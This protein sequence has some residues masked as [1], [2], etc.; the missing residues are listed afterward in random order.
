MDFKDTLHLPKTDFEMRGNLVSKQ[1]HY[2]QKWAD[3]NLYHLMREVNQDKTPFVFHDGPPYANGDIHVG[4]ALNKLLK[5]FVVRSR[6]KLGYRVHFVPGWDTHGLPIENEITKQGV[7]RKELPLS[8]F[9]ALCQQYAEKQ[10]Q[11]QMQE[12]KNLGTVADYDHPYITYHH[13]YEATQVELFAKMVERGMIYKGLKPVYWSPSSETALAEAEIEYKDKK[14]P[15]I[16]VRFK[17]KDG[18]GVLEEPNT[19][20]VIWTTTP[21]TIPGNLA[22]SLHPR[23]TYAQVKV[24]QDK[25]I[26]LEEFVEDL[27][28][29]FEFE[30]FE[31]TNRYLGSELEH[32]ITQHPLYDRDSIVILGEHVT[33]DSGTGCVHT[34]PG[35]GMD[36]YIVGLKYG[37][38]PYCNVDDRGRMMEM[39]GDWLAGQTTEEANKT[40]TNR[41]HEQGDLL[42][43]DFIT[44]SYPHDWRTKQPII[45]RATDQWFASIDVIRDELLEQVE[46]VEWM[47][48]WGKLRMTN[49][50]KDR[51]DWTISRQ[52]A[53]GLPI[54]IFYAQDKTPIM[55]QEVF[56]HVADLFR[57]HGS[58]IWFEKEAK[59]LLPEGYTH[60]NSP[61]GI[62]TKEKDIL[63]VWFDSGSSHTAALAKH[64]LKVPHD[65]YLEGSDQYRGWFNSSLII[66]TAVFNTAPYKQVLTHGFIVDE[67]GEK[68]SKSKGKALQP[69][70]VTERLGAEILRLWVASV[71]YTSDVSISDALLKQVAEQYRKIRNTFRF[72]HGNIANFKESDRL[73][74]NTLPSVDREVLYQLDNLLKSNLKAYEAYDF[75][76]VTS[77]VS[78]FLTNEMSAYYLDFTKDILYIHSENDLRRRQVQTVLSIALEALMHLLAPI[79]SFTMEELYEIV[80]PEKDSVHLD[81]FI[82]GVD[83][84]FSEQEQADFQELFD[85]RTSV[86]KALEEARAAKEIGNSLKAKVSLN[87]S[88][89]LK[90]LVDKH[91]GE[92]IK[93]WFIVSD[94]EFT[95]DE[96]PQVL[97]HQVLV[98]PALGETCE[99]CWNVVPETHEGIC[100]RCQHHLRV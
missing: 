41:L 71:D 100:E 72:M 62:F 49:M 70:A 60:P 19:Y 94:V 24:G 28:K 80:H 9:R 63:D 22:I 76:Q 82:T 95:T 7:N 87:I 36:D 66:S 92:A 25:Y 10:V 31:I 84:E 65:L 57:E 83:V 53:W 42:R 81:E 20:F 64:G 73:E 68:F 37:L 8:E 91:F 13:D 74:I 93:Q 54:P 48:S 96:L 1:D 40:V 75:S 27:M 44:H 46:K 51:M 61:D 3:L 34:A 52:R 12:M 79:L 15:A 39:A 4:H 50:I 59:D 35:F 89:D 47:P 26:V 97:N 2:I 30:E 86:Y 99:R 29:I 88:D 5:D 85:L 78:K 33:N 55:D 16:Y 23:Y 18:Q 69:K 98:T 21:W 56:Q 38:Q 58:N 11:L 67:K 6:H 45:F 14:D 17:V 32:V 90:A 43:L 77:S